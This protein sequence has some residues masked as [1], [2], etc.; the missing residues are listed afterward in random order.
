MAR[1]P[2]EDPLNPIESH[3]KTPRRKTRKSVCALAPL[4]ETLPPAQSVPSTSAAPV[5]LFENEIPVFIFLSVIFLSSF[6]R[7]A[8]W[9]VDS[10]DKG[11]SR[12]VHRYLAAR[13]YRELRSRFDRKITDRKMGRKVRRVRSSPAK[14]AAFRPQAN[15]AAS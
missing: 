13:C 4:C 1:R 14:I 3:A 2:M 12:L 10:R 7:I 8:E 9:L 6:L 5:E 11:R 15:V